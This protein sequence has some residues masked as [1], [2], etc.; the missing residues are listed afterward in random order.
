MTFSKPTNSRS[1]R[2]QTR[3]FTRHYLVSN[4]YCLFTIAGNKL[5][6][7]TDD[8]RFSIK[9]PAQPGT[10]PIAYITFSILAGRRRIRV[11]AGHKVS[12]NRSGTIAIERLELEDGTPPEGPPPEVQN[13]NFNWCGQTHVHGEPDTPLTHERPLTP[14]I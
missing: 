8:V 6:T 5:T 1:S 7:A 11:P 13:T 12:L 3:I 9:F 4:I 2:A 14:R 10:L